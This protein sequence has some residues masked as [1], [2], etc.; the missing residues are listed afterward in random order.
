MV[1]PQKSGNKRLRLALV[2][3][4]SPSPRSYLTMKSQTVDRSR[5]LVHV[6]GMGFRSARE[7]GTALGA[8]MGVGV[9]QMEPT[10]PLFRAQATWPFSM[11]FRLLLHL[12]GICSFMQPDNIYRT[13]AICG[14][15]CLLIQPCNHSTFSLNIY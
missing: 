2:Q 9:G 4:F 10:F 15:I 7:K 13:S 14:K 1:S 3:L 5:C 11:K 12:R 6:L 8:V